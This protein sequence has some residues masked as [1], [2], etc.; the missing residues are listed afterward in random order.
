MATVQSHT[1]E[2]GSQISRHRRRPLVALALLV[3]LLASACGSAAAPTP[4]VLGPDP[5]ETIEPGVAATFAPAA[6]LSAEGP[7]VATVD[8]AAIPRQEW[9]D[10]VQ[11]IH[12]RYDLERAR[13]Q[14]AIQS[15]TIDQATA[16]TKLMD[17]A[18]RA[19]D[20]ESVATDDLVDLAFQKILAR[21]EG[22]TVT[23][24]EVDAA[25][26]AESKDDPTFLTDLAAK[27]SQA[28]YRRN[29]EAE[30]LAGKLRDLIVSR[31]TADSGE[32]VHLSEVFL[33][34][35]TPPNEGGDPGAI[36]LSQI[37][38]APNHDPNNAI[39]LPLDDPAWAQA[40]TE[41]QATAD[42]LRAI[43][44]TKQRSDKFAEIA[45][46]SSDD[47]DFAPLGGDMGW[48]SPDAIEESQKAAL[49]DQPHQPGEV[50][51][52]V[53]ISFGWVVEL[54]VE[55]RPPL[56]ER[57]AKVQQ[58][59]AAVGADFATI[60]REESD[61][62]EASKGG[63]LGWIAPFEADPQLAAALKTAGGIGT[64][65]GP[66]TLDDGVHFYRIEGR[67][68][69]TLSPDQ[70][71]QLHDTAFDTWYQ[72]RRDAAVASGRIVIPE[73]SP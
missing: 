1:G 21:D 68:T 2:V 8:G 35:D 15:G 41:A 33:Q 54:Y 6:S 44:D 40:R 63:D 22:V 67:E 58:R 56:A 26:A 14:H 10:R 64:L 38:Y 28:A 46:T 61:G 31:A 57:V 9:V 71:Q 60:A 18:A 34:S 70:R 12:F 55:R 52:P 30:T 32:Q 51:G 17:L 69:R 73:A 27:L 36:R 62:Q 20:A 59:L 72:D 5:S 42:S 19:A 4:L 3:S 53:Q 37:L 49:F 13:L 23:P 16:Q 24:A 29:L 25:Q 50:I 11:L 48:V 39:D 7:P 66:L 65:L 45:K 47:Q 43:A